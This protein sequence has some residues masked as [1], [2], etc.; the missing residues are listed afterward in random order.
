VLQNRR[1]LLLGSGEFEPW[2]E[3]AERAAADGADPSVVILPTA[4]ARE[5]D[6]VF[7]RWGSMGLEHYHAMGWP[8]TVLPV[9][10]R[11]DAEREELT[12]DLDAAGLVFFSGGNPKHLASTIEG[13]PLWRSLLAAM[14]RGAVFAGCS[15]GAMVAS[16][17]RAQAR[18]QGVRTSWIFGLGLVPNVS[19]G[20]HWDKTRLIPGMRWWVRSELPEG[21]WF[22]GIDECT[23]IVG[24]GYAWTVFGRGGAT[25][26]HAT[27]RRVYRAGERFST[28]A[29]ERGS[30]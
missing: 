12:A 24:D 15:A 8:A 28:E 11:A 26:V 21:S 1:F 14:E 25:V 7:D 4:S 18:E 17:S 20:V 16:Q 5:G 23:A 9:K 22:V 30:A 19:F 3:E 10:A 2:S 29:P 6:A 27:G 13:T